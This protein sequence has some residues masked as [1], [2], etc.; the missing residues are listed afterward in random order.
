MT[1]KGL[2]KLGGY[3][4]EVG[5]LRQE[6]SSQDWV[7]IAT[8]RAERPDHF[9][10]ERKTPKVWPKYKET[11]P[12]CNETKF[13]Q[14]EATLRLPDDP[15]SWQVRVF[16]NRYPAFS[17]HEEFRSRKI[18]PYRV[19]EST[20]YHEI[21]AT[22]WHNQTEAKMSLR[23]HALVLEALALRY[24][25]LKSKDSVNYIQIIKNHGPEAGGSLAHPHHQI[26]TVPVLPGD[27]ARY[28]N[29][30]E[31]YFKTHGREVFAD[32]I[33]F[34]RDS[35]DRVV[36]ENDDFIAFCPFASR[37]PFETWIVPKKSDPFFENITPAQ[38]DSLAE[39]MQYIFRRLH[40]G[41]NDPPYNYYLHSAPCD[42]TGFVCN[43][44]T[45]QHYRWHIEILPRLTT[46]GGFELGT[47]LEINTA[48]PEESAKFLR[49]LSPSSE[50][51]PEGVA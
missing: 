21:L 12:F 31:A 41:L 28:L 23:E 18:G 26:F 14:E 32:M 13:P 48:L 30:A 24:R 29:G 6:P 34:E 17:P 5:E 33:A 10:E 1:Q 43:L 4:A 20:G 50:G 7:V 36:F 27:I 22:R 45:F 3:P 42:T 49:E 51:E 38:R 11:C 9:A 47:G 15:D 46:F 8:G 2:K 25:D 40:K 44:K 19:V 39:A 35:G 16:P 37:V